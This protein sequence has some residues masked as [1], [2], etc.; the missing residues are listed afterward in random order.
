MCTIAILMTCFNRKDKTIKSLDSLRLATKKLTEFNIDIFLVN[1]GC[2]DG[3]R[4]SVVC[5]H[6]E[7]TI[8]EGD[9]NLFWNRGMYLA[10]TEAAKKKYDYYLWLNDDTFLF[11]NALVSMLTSSQIQLN[12][13]IIVGSTMSLNLD[14]ITYGGR[15]KS[16][17][18]ILPTSL[19]QE[20][21]HF[22]GNVVLVP[23]YVFEKVG[24]LDPIFHHAI[25]DF[26]YG[27]RARKQDIKAYVASSFIG[28]CEGHDNFSK[29]CQVETPF[30]QRVKTLYSSTCD[31][32][33]KQFFIFE[34]R[35]FGFC[36]AIFHQITIHL[37]LVF[38]NVWNKMKIDK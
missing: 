10:W 28:L 24:Y 15:N 17:S 38:P 21:D 27:L 2:T 1:D 3:T 29:W 22:N 25:G 12:K 26:D 30:R 6:P 36:K 32:N 23:K 37:R 34:K 18:L 19:L 35:H 11:E 13:A 31:C 9:G 20:C 33:P 16:G 7:V 5:L 8:I 4:E 14:R